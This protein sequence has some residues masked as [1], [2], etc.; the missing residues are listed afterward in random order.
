M[1]LTRVFRFLFILLVGI[2]F[3]ACQKELSFEGVG[4]G[5]GGTSGGTSVFTLDGAPGACAAPFIQGTYTA[6]KPLTAN[7]LVVI[8]ANVTVLGTYTITSGTANGISFSGSGTF[9]TLGLQPIQLNAAGTPI[10]A[11]TFNFLPGSKPC[12]FSITVTGSGGGGGTGTAVYSFNGTP[13]ACAAPTINGTYTAGTALNATTNTVVLKANVTTAGTYNVTTTAN[14]MTFIASGTFAATGANQNVTFVGSGTP[15]AAGSTNFIPGPTGGACTF[16]VTVGGATGP[17]AIFSFNGAP[18][19]C[20]T[21]VI[22]GTYT[23]GT[24]LTS[25]NTVVLKANVTTAGAYNIT[26]TANGITFTATGSFA[27]VGP[28]QNVTFNATGTPTVPGSTNFTPGGTTNGCTCTITVAPA[29]SGSTDFLR[30][31]IGGVAMV[32][33][34]GLSADNTSSLSGPSALSMDG[35]LSSATGKDTL[36]V[37]FANQSGP[38]ATGAYTNPTSQTQTKF[39]FVVYVDN[40]GVEYFASFII[41]NNFLGTI[42]TYTTTASTGTFSGVLYN[43]MGV[44]PGTRIVTSGAYSVTY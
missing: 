25:T 32:F 17:N 6:G 23:A 11:G 35:A 2:G 5:G 30:A 44:G 13:N 9:T 3:V 7:E 34:N 33:N 29:S 18:G 42:A 8:T 14:G 16:S 31:T 19:N 36:F 40:T 10:V 41:P 22:N 4:S 37:A 27:A 21:P 12:S 20:L 38:V 24:A 26:I 1:I 39:I 43:N 28:N 15:V